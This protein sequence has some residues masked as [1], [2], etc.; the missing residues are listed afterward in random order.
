ML[1]S[2]YG[3]LEKNTSKGR[4]LWH[5]SLFYVANFREADGL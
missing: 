2:T 1:I 3:K 4:G 5:T